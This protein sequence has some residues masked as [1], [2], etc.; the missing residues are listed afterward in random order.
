MA[1]YAHRSDPPGRLVDLDVQQ[2]RPAHLEPLFDD[3]AQRAVGLGRTRAAVAAE[4]RAR[5]TRRGILGN[6]GLRRI[7][8]RA[9][10]RTLELGIAAEDKD[11]LR[12]ITAEGRAPQRDVDVGA[13]EDTAIAHRY[14]E[15]RQ[16]TGDALRI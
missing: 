4:R 12:K 3:P 2:A 11:L 8:A 16:S 14:E 15:M 1:A 10:A 7:H 9:D 5:G 6:A 13:R